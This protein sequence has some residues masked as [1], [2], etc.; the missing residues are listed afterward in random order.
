M[1]EIRIKTIEQIEEI[2]QGIQNDLTNIGRVNYMENYRGQSLDTYKLE[3]GIARYEYW[4]CILKRKERKLF[5]RFVKKIKTN[6][7]EFIQN[8]YNRNN[9]VYQDEWFYQFQ[10]QHL[11]VKTRLM[12]WSIR[13]EIALLFAVNEEK[14]HGKDGQF[15][16]FKCPRQNI[17]ND[18]NLDELLHIHPLSINESYMI[19]S[20]SYSSPNDTEFIGE[21]RRRRQQGRFFTQ[22]FKNSLTPINEQPEFASHLIKLIIDGDSK[23]KLKKDLGQITDKWVYYRNDDNIDNVIKEIN[24]DINTASFWEKKPNF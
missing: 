14:H 3:S 21:R 20:P 23:L 22:S 12:D 10:A 18:G 15:W 16:I 8:P 11:G 24:N 7:I 9:A 6:Q 17:I 19:N 2:V 5:D 4:D 1:A 13:W